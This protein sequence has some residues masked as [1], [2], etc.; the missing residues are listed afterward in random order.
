MAC[1]DM[2][3]QLCAKNKF[4]MSKKKTIVVMGAT[5]AQGGGLARAILHDQNSEFTVRAVT[6]RADSEKAMAL[7]RQGAEI[8]EADVHDIESLIKAFEGA[9]GAFLVSF[10]WEH[11]SA[12]REWHELTNMAKASKIAGIEHVVYSTIEDT[13]DFMS[14]ADRRIPTLQGEYKVP[15]F[16]VKGEANYLFKELDVP[17]TFLLTSFYYENFITHRLGMEKGHDGELTFTLP[18]DDKK[19]PAIAVEDIGKSAYRILTKGKDLIGKSIGVA[20]DHISGEEFAA[21]FSE[22]LQENVI[23]RPLSHDA[24]RAIGFPGAEELGNMLQFKCLFNTE[25]RN[26]RSVALSKEL[27]PELQSFPNWLSEN[28]HLLSFQ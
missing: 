10:H 3:G 25:Y 24:Y 7:A 22:V 27:N 8:V 19:M 20:A 23:Y 28:K 2:S 11:L 9:Y 14:L 21:A 16:D 26:A 18:L 4:I 1:I 12:R 13:R 6:R 5:G 17:T 15:H